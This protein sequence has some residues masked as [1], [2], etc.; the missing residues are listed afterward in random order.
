[1]LVANPACEERQMSTVAAALAGGKTTIGFPSSEHVLVPV[2]K[3]PSAAIFKSRLS[4]G[5]DTPAVVGWTTKMSWP[6]AEGDDVVSVKLSSKAFGWTT[7]RETLFDREP[8]GFCSCTLTLPAIATS[9]GRI[10]AVHSAALLQLAVRVAPP[11]SSADP[12]TGA[13]AAKPPP[14]I[15]GVSPSTPRP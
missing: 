13:V 1:M 10:G 15:G 7:T 12:G 11:S 9:E 8:S 6:A 4:P 5:T 2:E 3:F 14:C